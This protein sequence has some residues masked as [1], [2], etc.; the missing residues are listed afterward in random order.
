MTLAHHRL[1]R[2]AIL[3]V[4]LL[5]CALVGTRVASGFFSG[6]GWGSGPLPIAQTETLS[7][8][9]VELAVGLYPGSG[10]GI[11][12]SVI[13]PSSQPARVSSLLLDT[14]LGTAGFSS[15]KAVCTRPE[16]LF[17]PQD[18]GGAG[19]TI[20][21]RTGGVNG[22]R[23]VRLPAAVAMGPGAASNCQGAT[24]TVYLKAGQ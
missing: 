10:V 12:V 19:W 21:A 15:S 11:S 9:P 13:N 2:I 14:S 3:V 24:F 4:A 20:P 23:L 5:L 18:N 1:T 16:L 6:G 8:E 7:V 22:F 17:A